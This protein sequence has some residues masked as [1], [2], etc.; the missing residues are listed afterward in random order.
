M[1]CYA[2][3]VHKPFIE[4]SIVQLLIKNSQIRQFK[5]FKILVQEFH[6]KVDL[7]FVN[8]LLEVL[9]TK[10]DSSAEEVKK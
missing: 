1:K 7:N 2:I 6:I 10:E 8:A 4:M 9:Q 5:Y 3:T